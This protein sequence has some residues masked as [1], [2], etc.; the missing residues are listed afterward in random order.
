MNIYFILLVLI[1]FIVLLTYILYTYKSQKTVES[2]DDNNSNNLSTQDETNSLSIQKG[3]QFNSSVYE[4]VSGSDGNIKEPWKTDA[5]KAIK[6]ISNGATFVSYLGKTGNNDY[7]KGNISS[8]AWSDT[9]DWILNSGS[10]N[11]HVVLQ[12]IQSDPT[13]GKVGIGCY[14][15]PNDKISVKGDVGIN[16]NLK[17]YE[18]NISSSLIDGSPITVGKTKSNLVINQPVNT[19]FNVNNNITVNSK[20]TSSKVNIVTNNN[21]KVGGELKTMTLNLKNNIFN[22]ITKKTDKY[23]TEPQICVGN[24]CLTENGLKLLSNFY[25]KNLLCIGEKTSTNT[26]KQRCLNVDQIRALNGQK[27]F[28]I[29]MN[30]NG[31]R[32]LQYDQKCNSSKE[33]CL[34]LAKHKHKDSW[35]QFFLDMSPCKNCENK[36]G[37]IEEETNET[38]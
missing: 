26:T 13:S 30:K 25:N 35:E 22:P 31:I 18:G 36:T 11:G 20:K 12:S 17:F 37:S 15:S 10:E 21:L 28:Y 2:F 33:K 23:S 27:P 5:E 6:D 24:S 34:K 14:A 19:T 9:H 4:I 8:F 38:W 1:L 32:S 29:Q 7:V 3:N 16:G